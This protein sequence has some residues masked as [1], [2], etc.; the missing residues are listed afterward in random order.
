MSALPWVGLG[1]LLGGLARYGLGLLVLRLAP[2]G[3][4][5]ATLLVNATGCLAIGLLSGYT[6]G[7]GAP[8]SDTARLFLITGFLGAYTTFSAFGIETI[9]LLRSGAMAQA[10]LHVVGNNVLALGA[11][12]VGMSLASR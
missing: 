3:F 2:T 6:A 4:P 12:W 7:R 1:S 9:Q 11:V 10:A 8:M 5:L